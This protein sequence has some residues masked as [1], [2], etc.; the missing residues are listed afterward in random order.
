MIRSYIKY[1]GG[2]SQLAIQLINLFPK[3]FDRYVE[4]FCGSASLFLSYY[5]NSRTRDIFLYKKY[6]KA[7]LNDINGRLINCHI[8][9]ANSLNELKVCLDNNEKEHAVNPEKFYIE[10]RK[11]VTNLLTDS[12]LLEQAARYIYI[13]KT[14]FNGLWR[15]NQK[16]EFNVPFN[17]KK[18]ISLYNKNIQICSSLFKKYVEFT[19]IDFRD[20]I[21]KYMSSGDFIFID[22]PY[23]PI[24]A[25]SSFTSYTEE[26]WNEKDTSDLADV[27]DIINKK[28]SYFMMTNSDA[29]KVYEI[30]GKWDILTLKAHRFVKALNGEEGRSKV[31]ETVI[32]NYR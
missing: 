7:I 9:V 4:L 23:E 21:N 31:N 28:K 1:V 32:R 29:P 13:N 25:T 5:G 14:S 3:Q 2:K 15:V 26:N 19:N 16:G 27:L 20:W 30:F 24:S 18:T 11:Q 10:N 8:Q 12:N 22:P 6:P 17:Q